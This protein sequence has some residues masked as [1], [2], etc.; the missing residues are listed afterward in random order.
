M[1]YLL[2]THVVLLW[3]TDPNCLS[4]KTR[5]IIAD[6]SNQVFVSS[7]SMWEMAIKCDLGKLNIPH[8]ILSTLRAEHIQILQLTAEEG[9]G[10]IDL[11][12]IHNDP[13][14]RILIVQAKVNDLVF[15]TKD[16]QIL[17]YPI[18]CFKAS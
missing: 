14:D 10:V 2:D 18:I 11:P 15:I 5:N 7:I 3:L 9:L 13:F 12:R 4:L 17:Q 6:K 16:S 1:R 8:N